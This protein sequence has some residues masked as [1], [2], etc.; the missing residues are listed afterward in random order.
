MFFPKTEINRSNPSLIHR[1]SASIRSRE[2]LSPHRTRRSRGNWVGD[3]E[4][5]QGTGTRAHVAMVASV[6][7]EVATPWRPSTVPPHSLPYL[8][9]PLCR[10][11]ARP[12]PA[13][14]RSRR[15]RTMSVH[16]PRRPRHPR[17]RP[18]RPPPRAS[19]A[20]RHALPS[21]PLHLDTVAAPHRPLWRA[22]ALSRPLPSPRPRRTGDRP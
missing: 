12:Q 5:R 11:Q 22:L 10:F 21:A 18:G 14:H 7:E 13:G 1:S 15:P 3:E 16:A 20:R 8:P 2:P 6:P 9:C 17:A 19:V 4:G